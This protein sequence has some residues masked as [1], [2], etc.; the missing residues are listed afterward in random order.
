MILFSGSSSFL[1]LLI[2]ILV[3]VMALGIA[4]PFHEFAHAF[5]A[6]RE[7]D[8]TAVAYKRYTLAMHSHIDVKGFLML[9]IFGFG[10]AKPVP[11]DERN[12]KHGK[13]SKFFVAIAGI[14]AN[15]ILGVIFTFL[16]VLIY[17]ISPTFYSSS[18][19]GSVLYE[20]LY[21]S[22]L[23]N[24]SLAFFNILPIYPLDGFRVVQVF[25]KPDNG[26]VRFM[27]RYSYI[28]MIILIV[29]YLYSYYYSWTV[30]PL[31]NGLLKLFSWM[32]GV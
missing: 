28:I 13:R 18:F 10:W 26:Y 4:M 25:A 14:I 19:F 31:A 3:F 29:S 27:N 1:E 21:L 8:Y 23:L 5:A 11:V 22:I 9:L 12:F 15:L 32:L 24:F 7:G 30:V 17:K 6:R 20:F 2:E 16:Y